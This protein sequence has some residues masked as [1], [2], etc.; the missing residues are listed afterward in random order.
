MSDAYAVLSEGRL[1][2]LGVRRRS[3]GEPGG[4]AE[5]G[6]RLPISSVV[7]QEK[8]L[9]EWG[10]AVNNDADVHRLESQT[11]RVVRSSHLPFVAVGIQSHRARQWFVLPRAVQLMALKIPI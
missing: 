9:V 10:S 5:Q 6:K 11:R 4:S 2:V 3:S 1:D 8:L 7:D